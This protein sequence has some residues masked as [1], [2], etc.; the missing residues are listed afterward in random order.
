M[1]SKPPLLTLLTNAGSG[2]GSAATQPAWRVP[3][4]LYA[5]GTP[6]VDVLAC[7]AVTIAS[8]G[9]TVVQAQGG[10]P[11]VLIPASMLSKAEAGGVCPALATGTGGAGRETGRVVRALGVVGAV[12]GVMV[13]L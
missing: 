4:G 1:L 10:E 2:S 5:P 12:V 7:A 6:L 13:M 11:Q 3:P 8:S 9:E